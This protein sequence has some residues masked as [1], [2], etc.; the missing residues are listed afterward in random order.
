[1]APS[2]FPATQ[3]SA[4]SEDAFIAS[5][6]LV[7]VVEPLCDSALDRAAQLTH[8][9][10][11][12]NARKCE[13][14]AA[15][16]RELR[17]AGMDIFTVESSDRFGQHGMVGLIAIAK[18]DGEALLDEAPPS[19][20]DDCEWASTVDVLA[21][22]PQGGHLHVRVWLLS[23]RSLHLGIEYHMLWHLAFSAD[24]SPPRLTCE[25]RY[26][27]GRRSQ[28]GCVRLT[29]YVGP[30]CA[31]SKPHNRERCIFQEDV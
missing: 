1:M 7:V 25:L 24:C 19:G 6:N 30:M 18:S 9:T 14:S 16:L 31:V 8:R 5:L 15:E 2:T 23:C 13:V 12:H 26:F 11:Q 28:A 3:A 21:A 29:M 22:P 17:D 10:N 4:A 27:Q 20:G